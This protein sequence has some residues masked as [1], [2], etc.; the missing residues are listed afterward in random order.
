MRLIDE[1]LPGLPR[2][3]NR[4]MSLGV[5]NAGCLERVAQLYFE[6][7]SQEETL[8]VAPLAFRSSWRRDALL[9]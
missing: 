5:R 1:P 2:R 6:L 4:I 9:E 7:S 8:F 3:L